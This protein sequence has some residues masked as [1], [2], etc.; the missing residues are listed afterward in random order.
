MKNS[1]LSRKTRRSLLV[2][3]GLG[4]LIPVSSCAVFSHRAKQWEKTVRRDPDGVLSHARSRTWEGQG[5]G[6]LLVHGFADGPHL[7]KTLGPSLAEQG[8]HVRAIRLPGWNESIEVKRH[9]SRN[10]WRKAIQSEMAALE[11]RGQ[12][13]I[14]MAHSLGA[15][16]ASDLTQSGTITPE[17][18]VFYA[19]L[20]RVSN[21]RS[22]FLTTRTWYKIGSRILPDSFIVE[23]LFRE[24]AVS[25]Q[26]RTPAERDPFNPKP[27]FTQIFTLMEEREQLPLTLPCP[28]MMVVSPHDKVIDTPTAME[29]MESVQAPAKLLRHEPETGHVIP[30]ELDP[31][32]ESTL[33]HTWIQEQGTSR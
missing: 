24:Q 23:S 18:L 10:E 31:T 22:P 3:T 28:I 32:M 2:L 27:I 15:C 20:F 12:P 8:Y 21:T 5:P 17:A 29:W 9:T 1:R 11:Q 30:L 16:I 4:L 33:I 7:W 13:V 25:G 6:I 19:P 26:A 14:L